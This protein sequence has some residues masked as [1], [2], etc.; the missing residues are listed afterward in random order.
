MTAKTEIF[1]A[2]GD[3]VDAALQAWGNVDPT[4][5]AMWSE[6]CERR[7]YL[8]DYRRW[9]SR[10]V[11]N[12][13]TAAPQAPALF[14]APAPVPQPVVVRASVVHDGT[15]VETLTLAGPEGAR[16]LREAALRDLRPAETTAARCRRYLELAKQIESASEAQGRPVSVA[17]VIGMAA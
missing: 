9:N 17:E 4:G 5:Y 13:A 7:Q 8:A 14:D 3:D 11:V 6:S 15:S 16:I 12:V 1:T 10:H 2:Y